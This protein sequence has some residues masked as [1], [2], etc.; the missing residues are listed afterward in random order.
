MYLPRLA[1]RLHATR[2]IHRIAAEVVGVF[3]L[4]D[5]SGYDAAGVQAKS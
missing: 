1:I 2:R 3:I 5:D 4:T